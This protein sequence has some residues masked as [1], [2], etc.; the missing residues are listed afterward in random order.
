M[1]LTSQPVFFQ[2]QFVWKRPLM[3]GNVL[4]AAFRDKLLLA[5]PILLWEVV[6][7]L[8]LATRNK[9]TRIGCFKSTQVI[10][11]SGLHMSL[12]WPLQLQKSAWKMANFTYLQKLI[13]CPQK[14]PE[15]ISKHCVVRQEWRLAF[16]EPATTLPTVLTQCHTVALRH[17]LLFLCFKRTFFVW[18]WS[19]DHLWVYIS[20]L[21]EGMI[22]F[23]INFEF[24]SRYVWESFEQIYSPLWR[25]VIRHQSPARQPPESQTGP[26]SP[27]KDHTAEF[28][29][30]WKVSVSTVTH[31]V[32]FTVNIRFQISEKPVSNVLL[33]SALTSVFMIYI[34]ER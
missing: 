19:I 11:A 13:C 34:L 26:L 2:S 12:Y 8:P 20:K 14:N 6:G 33:W 10:K 21:C 17:V 18:V 5:Q 7:N 23:F 29:R 31:T 27:G 15:L 24:C 22:V 25:F 16:K 32:H 1:T 3:V 30:T 28:P 4:F 9:W